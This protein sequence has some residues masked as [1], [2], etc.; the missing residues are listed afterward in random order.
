M[1]LQNLETAKKLES[2]TPNRFSQHF[3]KFGKN[4][5]YFNFGLIFI[6]SFFLWIFNKNYITSLLL[7]FIL[8]TLTYP[9]FCHISN[10]IKATFFK[11]DQNIA[12]FFTVIFVSVIFVTFV[13]FFWTKLR[14][15]SVGFVNLINDFVDN[16]PNSP[17]FLKTFNLNENQAQ[18]FVTSSRI[19]LNEWQ[20]RFTNGADFFKQILAV[21]NISQTIQFSQITLNRIFNFLV[22]FVVFCLAWFYGL[23]AG[24]KWRE[25]FFAIIPLSKKEK[26]WIE[27]DLISGIRNVIYA[28]LMSGIV[29]STICFLIMLLF[30]FESKFIIT[31]FVFLI[32][33]LPLSPTEIAYMPI[34]F[35]TFKENNVAGLLLIPIAESI[36]LW[37]NFV[38]IPGIISEGKEGNPLLILTSILSGVTIF[39]LMGFII[40][41]IIM[42]LVQTLYK[43]LVTRLEKTTV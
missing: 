34:I 27:K 30:G 36:I 32:S 7:G 18:E 29:H 31:V 42:V 22:Q 37:V 12:A 2:K 28:N 11:E 3:T 8:A 9:I 33:I 20:S 43:I 15:E 5:T 25:S 19:S 21:E 14:L 6:I 13:N 1:L 17:N 41:P 38:L 10:L 24:K 35:L 26:E 23:T 39:G 40:A 16:L 4:F